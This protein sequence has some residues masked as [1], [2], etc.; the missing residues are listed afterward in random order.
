MTAALSA[1]RQKLDLFGVMLIASITALGGGTVRDI[2]LG[3]YPLT[4]VGE[5]MY[6][7]VVLA[8]SI[9]TVSMSFFDALL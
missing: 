3:A 5:P 6:L 4:W 9:V 7:L 1:G 2:V 8:A